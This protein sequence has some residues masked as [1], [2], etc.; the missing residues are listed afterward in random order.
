MI[1]Y[2]L[3]CKNCEKSFDSWF[4]SSKEFEKLRSKKFLSC[5]FCNSKKIIKT[6]MAPNIM[7]ANQKLGNNLKMKKNNKIKKKF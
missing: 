3:K 7:T 2:K 1:K 5:H 4:S 6:L